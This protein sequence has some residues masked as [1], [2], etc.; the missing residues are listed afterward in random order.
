MLHRKQILSI[1]T[2]KS[3]QWDIIIIGGGATGVGTAIDASARGYKTLLLE[4]NDFGKGTSSRSTKLIHGGVR[5]LQQGNISL[6]LEALKERGLL[7]QNAPHLVHNIPFIVPRYD[8]WEGTFYGVGLKLYDMLAG[9]YGFGSSKLLSVDETIERIPTVETD[10]LRGGVVYYDGQFDDSRLLINM[11]QTADE[12]GTDIINYVSVS[13]LLKKNGIVTGVL[14]SD[15]ETG[16]E[17]ELKSRVVINATGIFSDSIRKMDDENTKPVIVHSRGTHIVLDKSFL[18]GDNAIMVPHTKDGRVLF[19]IP[20]Q[21]KVIV[22]T[23]DIE[24]DSPSLEPVANTD[25]F[26]FLLSTASQYLEKDPTRK[27]VLSTFSGI[28]PLVISGNEEDTAAISREHTVLISTSGLISIAGGKWTTYRKMAEDTIDQAIAVAGLEFKPSVTENLRIHGYTNAKIENE[29][30][31]MYG[32][33]ADDIEYFCKEKN[34]G[35]KL[36][37]AYEYIASEVVW[38]IRN[39]MARTVEDFLA[40]RIRILFLDANAAIEMAPIVAKLMAK[41]LKKKR[42]WVKE[43]IASF[44][45]VAKRF[46]IN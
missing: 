34:L 37:P 29:Y 40:R 9:K 19:A 22:G 1:L 28:R 31:S 43:Q 26:E 35:E 17:Y 14:A 32:S 39:T 44:N 33:D 41:E 5:Y 10:G 12:L 6:V 25:E 38:S 4:Q 36:H 15:T 13:S 11:V 16:T 7:H 45:D 2:D 20:W 30:L 8:W 21:N 3:E 42:S 23:T 46:L 27:D 24:V 18:P